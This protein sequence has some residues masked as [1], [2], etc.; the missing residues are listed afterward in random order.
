MSTRIKPAPPI[1]AGAF[2]GLVLASASAGLFFTFAS[3]LVAQD[4]PLD[5]HSSIRIDFPPDSPV[6]ALTASTDVGPSRATAR[7]GAMVV[8]LHMGLS[9]RNSGS[10]NI[11]G[12]TLLV[13][14]QAVTPGGRASV[15]VPSLNIAPGQTFPVR[16]DLRL[17]RPLQAGGGPLVKVSLDGVLFENLDFYGPNLLNSRRSMTAWETEAERDRKHF[18]SVLA[19]AG[20]E[21]LQREMLDSLARQAE[22]PH[23]DVRVSRGGRTVSSAATT[24][25]VARFAFLRIPESPVE[26]VDGWAEV[27]GNEARTP[28]IE[29]LNRS[30]RPVRYVEIGWIV[31]DRQGREFLAGAVPAAESDL[32]LP[33]GQSGRVLQDTVLRFSRNAGEPVS[34]ESISGFVSQVEFADGKVWVP[35]RAALQHSGLLRVVAPSPEEQRLA[36][37]Y[38]TK[39]LGM[40]MQELQK[41]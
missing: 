25:R 10:R 24:E 1:L 8:D 20:P 3:A 26:A 11:R 4:A 29:V 28:T 30:S 27:G 2:A 9:L 35:N 39:G 13:T 34:I 5:P 14:A 31:K 18:K 19:S 37:L 22:R 40:L 21:G 36:D 6:V 16:I 32:F 12:V 41:Y 23:I 38:R 15:A 7:G 17:L 33:P